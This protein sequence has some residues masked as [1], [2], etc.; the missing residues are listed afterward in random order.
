MW[1]V[2]FAVG[3]KGLDTEGQHRE[4]A[5]DFL[6]WKYCKILKVPWKP[7][8]PNDEIMRTIGGYRELLSTI[9]Y[10]KTVYVGN[11]KYASNTSRREARVK[12]RNAQK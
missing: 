3:H 12:K 7:R 6:V 5:G 1:S 2:L 4:W 9:E 10:R 8:K 11:L